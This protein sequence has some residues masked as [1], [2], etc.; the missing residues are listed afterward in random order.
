M[1]GKALQDHMFRSYFDMRYGMAI[2]G[3]AFPIVVYAAGLYDHVPVQK[4][5]SHYYWATGNGEY[6]ARIWFIGG[7]FALAALLYLYRGFSRKEDRALNIAA[8]FAVGVAIFPMPRSNTGEFWSVHGF[9]AMALFACLVYV[10]WRHAEDT[11]QYL[12][13]KKDG[14]DQKALIRKYS[15]AYKIIGLLLAASPVSALLLNWFFA[16]GTAYTFFIESAGIWGFALFW[17]VKSTE[18]SKSDATNKGLRGELE[19]PT[20]AAASGMKKGT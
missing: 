19:P 1:A 16:G 8:L 17:W 12:P 7:L 11:L 13:D 14:I 15:R 18:L 2:I 9:C 6:I 4:S 3:F 5:L 20:Q 10:A